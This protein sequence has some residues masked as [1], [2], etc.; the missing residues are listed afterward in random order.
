MR[1][2][3][4]RIGSL[5]PTN[6]ARRCERSV[7]LIR[8]L[9]SP[10]QSSDLPAQ[11]GRRC[12]PE[13][14]Q[15]QPPLPPLG[16]SA[17]GCSRPGSRPPPVGCCPVGTFKLLPPPGSRYPRP[18]WPPDPAPPA[19]GRAWDAGPA[20]GGAGRR[21]PWVRAPQAGGP[22]RDGPRARAGETACLQRG[23][24]LAGSQTAGRNGRGAGAGP[25]CGGVGQSLQNRPKGRPAVSQSINRHRVPSTGPGAGDRRRE[26]RPCPCPIPS[27]GRAPI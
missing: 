3:W 26:G 4:S 16:A 24:R 18:T 19:N 17:G 11:P 14:C 9:P 7:G 15:G 21:E 12:L 23:A 1:S 6:Q 25:R 2:P 22:T 10:A 20:N 13:P 8:P 27:Q 5:W